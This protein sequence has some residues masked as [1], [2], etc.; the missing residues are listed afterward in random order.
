MSAAAKVTGD[1]RGVV[2]L[3]GF[4]LDELLEKLTRLDGPVER[5]QQPAVERAQAVPITPGR[6]VWV[7]ASADGTG[8]PS[9]GFH[10]AIL[11]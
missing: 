6:S 5:H 9:L 3:V 2:P 8:G 1:V 11:S 7:I 10:G 4:G